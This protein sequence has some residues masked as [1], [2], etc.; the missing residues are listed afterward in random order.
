MG[1]LTPLLQPGVRVTVQVQQFSLRCPGD[2]AHSAHRASPPTLGAKR[3][4]FLKAA[5][6]KEV[7]PPRG[8]GTDCSQKLPPPHIASPPPAKLG[9]EQRKAL[10][11]FP[12]LAK[13]RVLSCMGVGVGSTKRPCHRDWGTPASRGADPHSPTSYTANML[14]CSVPTRPKKD[15]CREMSGQKEALTPS[16]TWFTEH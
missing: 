11:A 7:I 4:H 14:I 3:T 8:G 2:T 10:R 15:N 16:C 9:G 12:F 13:G 6:N 5:T 1:C